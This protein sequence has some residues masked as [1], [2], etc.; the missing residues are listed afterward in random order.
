MPCRPRWSAV[1]L[2]TTETSLRVSPMPLSRMPPRAVSVTASSTSRVRQHPAGAARARSSRPPRPARRRCRCRRCWTSRPA[3]RR[4]GAMWAIIRL[5]VVLPLVPV[6]A[7]TGTRGRDRGRAGRPGRRRRPAR[8]AALTAVLDVGRSGSASSTS[9]TAR[10]ISWARSR[11]RHGKA[12][13]SWCGSLVGRTRT[14]SRAVPD[15][16]RDRAHQPGHRAQRE[17]L[18]EAGVGRPRPRVAQPDPAREAARR[19]RRRGRQPADVEG[20]LDRRA[21]EVEVRALEDPELDQGRHGGD[22]TRTSAERSGTHGVEAAV[23]VHDL[24]GRG[25]EEVATAARRRPAPSAS[26]SV[27]SQPSGARSLPHRL[28]VL[29]AGDRLGGQR[30]AAGRRETRLHRMPSGPRSRA[31]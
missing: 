27:S 9:A 30:L 4:C 19:S 15:S 18:P 13:T 24:A 14:A 31:R 2:V 10:P 1:T 16:A 21:R 23:D 28:E 25:R 6:T 5:V 8:A 26:W 3:C 29:E 7:T 17:P 22:A 12:T 11:C 20:Q